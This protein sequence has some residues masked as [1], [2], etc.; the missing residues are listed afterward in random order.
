[1]TCARLSCAAVSLRRV[2]CDGITW[3]QAHHQTHIGSNACFYLGIALIVVR[4]AV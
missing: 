2:G 1:M 4:Q 3:I